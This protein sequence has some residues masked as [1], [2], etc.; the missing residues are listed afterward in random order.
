MIFVKIT[1]FFDAESKELYRYNGFLCSSNFKKFIRFDQIDSEY[2]KASIPSKAFAFCNCFSIFSQCHWVRNFIRRFQLKTSIFLSSTTA[3]CWND[4]MWAFFLLFKNLNWPIHSCALIEIILNILVI[5]ELHRV[6]F[7]Y[8]VSV[9]VY[10]P[11]LNDKNWQ[12]ISQ[13][14]FLSFK[15]LARGKEQHD[16]LLG[17]P[18]KIRYFCV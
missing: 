18:K 13:E 14:Q 8:S 9:S 6:F 17:T 5:I 10:T 16:L 1:D 7:R 4:L 2:I 12:K 15:I 3:F 11:T